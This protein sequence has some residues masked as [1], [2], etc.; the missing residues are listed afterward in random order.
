VVAPA[1]F[2]VDAG[3]VEVAA[4][5]GVTGVGG[6]EQVPDDDLNGRADGHHGFL[7][8]ASAL[9]AMACTNGSSVAVSATVATASSALNPEQ[10]SICI[11]QPE[12]TVFGARRPQ[13]II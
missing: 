12:L 6:G 4:E 3:V 13:R 7:S 11:W 10:F 8:A 9:L 5:V 2:G 1:A